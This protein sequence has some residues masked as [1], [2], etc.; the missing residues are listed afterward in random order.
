MSVWRIAEIQK[1][2]RRRH[3]E[4]IRENLM[5]E[6]ITLRY[7]EWTY[8]LAEDDFKVTSCIFI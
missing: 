5:I 1:V 8:S 4:E 3:L 7:Y 6:L 2:A